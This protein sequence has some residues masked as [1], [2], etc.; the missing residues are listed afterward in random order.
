MMIHVFELYILPLMNYI[1]LY[2]LLC[3]FHPM[4]TQQAQGYA[5][6]QLKAGSAQTLGINTQSWIYI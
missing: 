1:W 4:K 3:G 6:L 2:S 5:A